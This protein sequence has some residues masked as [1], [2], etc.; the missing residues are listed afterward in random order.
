MSF[1]PPWRWLTSPQLRPTKPT[2]LP[3]SHIPT[4]AHT[5][6]QR[7]P[8]AQAHKT[9]RSSGL[10]HTHICTHSATEIQLLGHVLGTQIHTRTHASI[11][12]HGC[13]LAGACV[14]PAQDTRRK[15]SLKPCIFLPART[16]CCCGGSDGPGPSQGGVTGPRIKGDLGL[17]QLPN[18]SWHFAGGPCGLW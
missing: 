4:S 3:D 1:P 8:T 7:V 17:S 12:A 5:Q 2:G 10:S 11:H 18:A 9:H 6:P 14:T 16:G 13:T 15:L